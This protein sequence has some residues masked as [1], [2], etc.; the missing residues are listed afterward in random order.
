MSF[1]ITRLNGASAGGHALQLLAVAAPA[2]HN[3]SAAAVSF[4]AA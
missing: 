2:A 4:S 1:A 3:S